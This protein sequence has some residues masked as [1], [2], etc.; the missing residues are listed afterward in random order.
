[1]KQNKKTE[2]LTILY[3]PRYKCHVSYTITHLKAESRTENKAEEAAPVI[4]KTQSSL[5]FIA[6]RRKSR[7]TP[8]HTLFIFIE[9]TQNDL[10][11]WFEDEEDLAFAKST[12]SLKSA[13]SGFSG[14]D[15][16]EELIE[17]F[18]VCPTMLS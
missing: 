2:I 14:L 12:R 6:T 8:H 18:F 5:I 13:S 16:E 1:M 4:H 17:R 11:D 9:I 15:G 7:Y 3:D 10:L